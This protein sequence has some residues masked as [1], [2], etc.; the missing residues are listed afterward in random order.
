[1]TSDLICLGEPLAEFNQQPDGTYRFGYGGDTSNCAVAAA[2]QG[3]RVGYVTH[4]G[5][6]MFGQAF[7]DL[8][9]RENIDTTGTRS[10]GDA[11]T[12]LYFVTH[13]A[14]GHTF[15]Y[16][17]AGSA[18]SRMRTEDLPR[19]VLRQARILHVSG[20]SQAISPQATDAVLA[21][22][23]EVR[24][25]GGR[26][27][28]DTNLRLALWPLD[29]A[30]AVTHQAMAHCDIALPGLEDAGQLTG[31]A[32]PDAIADFYLT[33]GAKVVALTLGAEGVLVATHDE[34]RRVRG[35]RV[36][37]IDATGAGDTFDGAFLARLLA[38][39]DPFAAAR[40]A[41]AAAAL[42]TLGYGAVAPIPNEKAVL[43][44][45]ADHQE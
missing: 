12:G 39:D 25:A 7:L 11:P 35:Y 18:S 29:Q 44:F 14:R 17:R 13:T 21:A 5:A 23:D 37:A 30:R 9:Q 42:S 8:W 36:A 31:L 41:N 28:Y 24:N 40:Y 26:I 10:V 19:Q 27:S 32:D 6:D 20:I 45:L 4:L 22:I 33:L 38:G 2:R 1:M 34:R 43:A 16:R 15:T 3:A